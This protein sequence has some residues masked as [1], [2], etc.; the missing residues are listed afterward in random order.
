MSDNRYRE[1]DHLFKLAEEK[2]KQIENLQN[3]GLS[4]PSINQLRY[5]G[6]HT[7]ASLV[8]NNEKVINDNIYEA[9]DHCKRAIYDAMEIGIVFLL[10][11]IKSFKEEYRFVTITDIIPDY[12]KKLQRVEEIKNFIGQ[13]SRNKVESFNQ[14]QAVFDEIKQIY[15]EF[16]IS[17]EELNKKYNNYRKNFTLLLI[18]I[19]IAIFGILLT[20]LTFLL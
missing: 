12:V 5:A 11:N 1:L 18:P 19:F 2:I 6:Q 10:G 16:D 17:R 8:A 20:I 13:A 14:V 9:K 4:I 3:D 15:S 7:L